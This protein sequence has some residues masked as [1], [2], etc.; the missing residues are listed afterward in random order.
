MP[1]GTS[2]QFSKNQFTTIIISYKNVVKKV[3]NDL[4]SFLLIFIKSIVVVPTG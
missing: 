3:L 1:N 2:N 4:I